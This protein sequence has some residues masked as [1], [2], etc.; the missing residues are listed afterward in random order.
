[1][2]NAK[3]HNASASLHLNAYT[4]WLITFFATF[5]LPDIV[6]PQGLQLILQAISKNT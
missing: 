5:E 1:M 6:S 2:G 3:R 4:E